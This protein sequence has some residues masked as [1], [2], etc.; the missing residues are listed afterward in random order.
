MEE[1]V[2]FSPLQ[3]VISA[4]RP[5]PDYLAGT[6]GTYG[7]S[8]TTENTHTKPKMPAPRLSAPKNPTSFP[9]MTR[10]PLLHTL[11]STVLQPS[12]PINSPSIPS[13]ASLRS[14]CTSFSHPKMSDKTH[15][16]SIRNEFPDDPETLGNYPTPLSPPLPPISKQIELNRAMSASSRASLFSVSPVDVLFQDDW[17]IVVNKPQGVYCEAVL[18]SIPRIFGDTAVNSHGLGEWFVISRFLQSE[19]LV[20]LIYWWYLFWGVFS[21]PILARPFSYVLFTLSNEA[22]ENEKWQAAKNRQEKDFNWWIL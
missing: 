9:Y 22:I 19:L 13:L 2:T 8:S 10:V 4:K 1:K 16:H 17:L 3:E 14:L 21:F 11:P 18:S 20:A 12:F 5:P 6:L 15:I 7:S